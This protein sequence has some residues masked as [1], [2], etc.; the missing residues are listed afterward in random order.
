MR[1]FQKYRY[2]SLAIVLTAT[3]LILGFYLVMAD[4]AVNSVRSALF[5]AFVADG[6]A[7]Y[8]TIRKLWRTKWKKLFVSSVQ[9]II[10]KIAKRLTDFFEKRT[11]GKKTTVLSCKTTV[12]FDFPLQEFS[13]KKSSKTIRWKSLKNDRE[14]LGY[15]YKS[16]IELN[17][18]H[19]LLV[20]SSDTPIEVKMK[21]E[22][23]T[24]E[25]QIFDL[26]ITNRYN[27]TLKIDAN[28]LNELKKLCK[29][30]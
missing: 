29:Y 21:K 9:K 14:R 28:I 12:T 11:R 7:L 20:F 16:V 6:V 22:Y 1:T 10:T 17:I 5:A 18:N 26:Y 3:L 13:K 25:N 8:F 27:D 4:F 30:L 24:F 15:L 2:E 19:G 23:E